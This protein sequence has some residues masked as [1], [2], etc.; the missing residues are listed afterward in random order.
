MPAYVNS[1]NQPAILVQE[2]TLAYLFG[3]YNAHQANTKMW[4]TN[5]ALTTN[6]ATLT[7]QIIEGEIPLVGAY[8]TV[9]Q[10]QAGSGAMNVN[11]AVITGVTINATTGAGTITYAVTSA[12]ITS[13]ADHG[14]AIAEVYEIPETLVAGMS[15]ACVFQAPKGDS[16][17]TVPLSVLCPTMPTAATFTLMRALRNVQNEFTATTAV[18]TIATSAFTA[19]PTV[20]ATLERGYFY[21]VNVSGITGTGTIV[22]K[23]GG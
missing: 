18:V 7:V 17:F 23:I 9:T 5:S 16:Q 3:T 19:G 10:T 12:N 2:G 22:A 11:R 13:V 4:V 6:V 1:P 20:L 8:L 15:I 21:A 14:T